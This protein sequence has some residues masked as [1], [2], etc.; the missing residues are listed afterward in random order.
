MKEIAKKFESLQ[1]WLTVIFL[2]IMACSSFFQVLNRNIFMLTIS[3]TEELSRYCMIWMTMI[4]TGISVRKGTQ[5]G[6]D[7]WGD[8]LKGT[9]RVISDLLICVLIIAFCGIVMVSVIQL[10][11]VQI[12]GSQESPALHIPMWI[13][14][15]AIFIGMLFI[16][17]VEIEN[18]VKVILSRNKSDDSKE[19][20]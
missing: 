17:V 1:S 9:A 15:L 5:M 11:A 3:W 2:S 10:I 16:C 6:I 8:R 19:G 13:M 12:H 4:A 20:I 18:T 7:I 14:T